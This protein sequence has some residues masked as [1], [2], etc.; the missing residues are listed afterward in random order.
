MSNPQLIATAT[1][2]TEQPAVCCQQRRRMM[3]PLW[4]PRG[5]KRT[6]SAARSLTELFEARGRNQLA[7]AL[8]RWMVELGASAPRTPEVPVREHCLLVRA[9]A[10]AVLDLY[11][12]AQGARFRLN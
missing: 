8:S 3:E 1:R 5:C 4:S 11:E 6:R 7:Q 10:I 2:L 12:A 9:P